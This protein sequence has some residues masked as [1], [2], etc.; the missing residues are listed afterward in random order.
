[1]S[2]KKRDTQ[3]KR[4][5]DDFGTVVVPV[6]DEE[7]A[8]LIREAAE[9]EIVAE[10][11]KLNETEEVIE[12]EDAEDADVDEAADKYKS[13]DQAEVESE[14]SDLLDE[15]EV[16]KD[17]ITEDMQSTGDSEKGELQKEIVRLRTENAQL[18]VRNKAINSTNI[19]L[20]DTVYTLQN[21]LVAEKQNTL[22]KDVPRFGSASEVPEKYIG[23]MTL[24][25]KAASLENTQK[26]IAIL[27]D[28]QKALALHLIVNN[29]AAAERALATAKFVV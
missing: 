8:A 14:T 16:I 20:K 13:I 26:F 7:E 19:N 2:K 6:T 15:P 5:M 24:Q 25:I 23:N 29:R 10:D 9:N 17:K 21:N 22:L 27:S 4:G 28:K 3:A 18:K 12:A 11:A 1:M